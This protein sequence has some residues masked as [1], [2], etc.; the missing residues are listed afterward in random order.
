MIRKNKAH[1][2]LPTTEGDFCRTNRIACI[3][4][5][6]HTHTETPA[7]T[8][9][10]VRSGTLLIVYFLPLPLDLISEQNMRNAADSN[11]NNLDLNDRL[12]IENFNTLEQFEKFNMKRPSEGQKSNNNFVLPENFE[13]VQD[14]MSI[15]NN[16]QYEVLSSNMT[17]SNFNQ[18][19]KGNVYFNANQQ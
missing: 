17:N 8:Y 11:L 19:Q 4:T 3:S 15:I 12:M 13:D 14:Q 10:N 16:E 5:H 6:T 2:P 18:L 9:L 1:R 7:I